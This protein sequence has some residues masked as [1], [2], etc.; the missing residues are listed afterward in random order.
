MLIF[1]TVV[2]I[3][4]YCEGSLLLSPVFRVYGFSVAKDRGIVIVQVEY[5]ERNIY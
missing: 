1:I 3:D 5:N 4:W 2:D